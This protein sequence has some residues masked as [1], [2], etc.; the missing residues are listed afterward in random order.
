MNF[1]KLVKSIKVKRTAGP[2]V[3]MLLAFLS[4]LTL[5]QSIFTNPITNSNPSASNPFTFGQTVNTN[6]TVSG[7]GRGAGIS[8]NAGQDR[9][10]AN[11]WNTPSLDATA[12]FE[13]IITPNS[14]YGINFSSFVYSGQ[15]SGTGPT[16]FAFRSSLDNYST[17]IGTPTAPGTSISLSSASYQGIT[18]AITF[19][20]YGWGASGG[21]G[22]YSINDFTFNGTLTALPLYWDVTAGAGNGVGG[23]GIWGNTFSVSST[24]STSLTSSTASS[25]VN[26]EGTPGTVFLS[27][28]RT[29]NSIEVNVPGYTFSTSTTGDI[30]LTSPFDMNSNSITCSTG[31]SSNLI[32]SSVI[33][34]SVTASTTALTKTGDGTLTLG[35][36]N[37]FTG[38]VA[39]NG[40][41]IAASGEARF[42]PN[43]GSFTADQITLNGGGIATTASSN[44]DFSSNRGITLGLS[45]GTFSPASSQS[46]TL[47]NVV[48][49]SGRL[50]MSGSGTL[51][52]A[53]AHTY[54][55]NTTINSGTIRLNA[56]DRISNSSILQFSSG[57]FSTGSGSGFSETLGG[58]NLSGTGTI[59]LGTGDHSLTFANS[60]AITWGGSSLVITGWT[61]TAGSSGTGGKIFVG[62]GGLTSGQLAKVRFNGYPGSSEILPSGELVP[63]GASGLSD[64]ILNSFFTHPSNI[65]YQIHQASDIDFSGTS[66]HVAR[67]TIRD[68]GGASDVDVLGTT[69]TAITFSLS[70]HANIRRI[71]L[72]DGSTEVGEVNGAASISFGSLNI[73]A[74]DGD[75]KIFD[76]RV[77]FNST[78]TDNQ[79]FQFAITSATALASGSGFAAAD[80]G[81]AQSSIASN[82]NRIE[83]TATKLRYIQQP[84][85]VQAGSIISPN[86]S[87]EA[88]DANDNRDLDF[89]G[90]ITLSITSTTCGTLTGNAE[91]ASSGLA[92][93][94][95]LTPGVAENAITLA[96]SN[97]GSLTNATSSPT[98]NVTAAAASEETLVGWNF[99][100]E[101]TLRTSGNTNNTTNTL[102]T[103][104]TGSIS[105]FAGASGQAPGVTS[106]NGGLNTKWWEVS[107]NTTGYSTI[108]ISSKQYG[109]NNSP[110]NFN[111]Q[112]KI[113]VGGT[114]STITSVVVD[115]DW[116]SG[117]LS[118]V[119]VP[120]DAENKPSVFFRW[121]MSSNTAVDG[122]AVG[123]SGRSRIDDI[124]ITGVTLTPVANLFFRSKATGNFNAVCT[125]ESSTDNSTWVQAP[126]AP[127]FSSRTITIRDGHAV[128]I[129]SDV[130][131][132][133][134]VVAT[135]GTL[136][137]QDFD[138]NLN[139]GTGIDFQV[140]GTFIDNASNANGAAFSTS[141]TWSMGA[142]A[143]FIKTRNGPLIPF[144]TGYDGGISGIPATANWIWR[145]TGSN[146]SILSV[147]GMFYP[148]LTIESNSGVYA[149]TIEVFSGSSDFP[150]IKG[151][152]DIGG[153][154]SG[155]VTFL[156]NN[157]NTQ[158]LRISGDLIVRT[159]SSLS[160]NATGTGFEV[161]GN[162]A[163]DG[164]LIVS[165]AAPRR[166]ELT[167]TTQNQTI[168]GT[169]TLTISQFV[170]NNTQTVFLQKDLTVSLAFTSNAGTFDAGTNVLSG[171]GSAFTLANGASVKLGKL[172]ST[173]PEAFST[174]TLGTTSTV[175]LNGA[176]DQTLRDL[177]YG[178]LIFSG[179]GVKTLPSTELLV[180]GNLTING[181]STN[182]NNGTVTL[183]STGAQTIG[184][185]GTFTLY[186]LGTAS[187]GSKVA[188]ANINLQN[189]FTLSG[190]ATFDADGAAGN[191]LFSLVSTASGT[192]RIA[193][194][195]VPNNF[196][197]AIAMQRYNG[198]YRRARYFTPAVQGLT[199]QDLRD[200]ILI[201]GPSG[202]DGPVRLIS[203]IRY[204]NELS[205][206]TSN[207]LAWTSLR[208]TSDGL[209]PG[210]GYYLFVPGRR[211][212]AAMNS[213]P[214]VLVSQGL[215]NKGTV[216]L[217]VSNSTPI[218]PTLGVAGWNLVGNPYPCEINWD[219][220]TGWTKT[221]MN[222]AI[223]FWDP[224]IGLNGAYFSYVGGSTIS[225]D[226]RPNP[227]VIPSSQGFFVR[228]SGDNPVLQV[229]EA[230]KVTQPSHKPNFRTTGAENQ[231][232]RIK[233]QSSVTE[234]HAV[235]YWS[236]GATTSF[237]G[238]KDAFKLIS[239]ELNLALISEDQKLLSIQ[240]L[241]PAVDTFRV[242]L[243]LSSVTLG[244][245]TLSFVDVSKEEVFLADL[246]T[247]DTIQV[248][249]G[250]S[251]TFEVS[252]EPSS[253]G[254]SRF[255]LFKKPSPKVMEPEDE[256]QVLG[257]KSGISYIVYIFPNPVTQE[258]IIVS[259]IPNVKSLSIVSMEGKVVGIDTNPTLLG[260]M[261]W[262]TDLLSGQPAGSYVLQIQTND[263][264]Y[265]RLVVKP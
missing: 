230:A 197:G 233:V 153:N 221:N 79:Q 160:N 86:V 17:D 264:T 57:T 149:P 131:L 3:F 223:Y 244:A 116:T 183:N 123:S 13:F 210:R 141:A 178:H 165:G 69:L 249:E 99:D 137:L 151:N 256:D 121:I 27:A 126:S 22:T 159:G 122:G 56:S 169:G 8:A 161:Q 70:N 184:G 25:L 87:V 49:G 45:G 50:A 199:V 115:E 53:G 237:D 255:N 10:N 52:M 235:V 238:Q 225:L 92:T 89:T 202:F 26:F 234:D 150:T 35:S 148:N 201:N 212:G 164:T 232:I 174:Y 172:S 16:T 38:K 5:A 39:I 11:S 193:A 143:T 20:F 227:N 125:W 97:T 226:G 88:A 251:Y 167:S 15:A 215:P 105:Y 182:P 144:R 74:S 9:Y 203:S 113:G 106:W 179:S 107:V 156:N 110:R 19:R 243:D 114:W 59:A 30:T 177:D 171:S 145:Y 176:G 94:T 147:D 71:A 142:S 93:F 254:S 24:G 103:T 180:N 188:E 129:N 34:G 263:L 140:N 77:S 152:L 170:N 220:L 64:I 96:T 190:T 75:V 101:S 84:S 1:S 246:F 181:G 258:R 194:L 48:T 40:G 229:S 23:T 218:D 187:S 28:N 6:I 216:T 21:T 240:G 206:A 208:F 257:N 82:D 239:S 108:K 73:N 196:S 214:V 213:E 120:S 217:P 245:Q 209:T 118:N 185:T 76:L 68:G 146:I 90:T 242:W 95:T 111:L 36:N 4:N 173:L 109:S 163:I 37:T 207:N 18:S 204:Y 133:E 112:Y 117:V 211:N 247:G 260:N 7:I 58:L 63:P 102:S 241:D 81:G 253:K 46:I 175:E 186:N 12:Y 262:E 192:A 135:G 80:A 91:A 168:S 128:T 166:L 104:G 47:T 33:T 85:N 265:Q 236:E 29:V 42:G 127:D 157:T 32:L 250:V 65:S 130:T 189:T 72:Y 224:T 31:T 41:F 259:G 78:V 155:T 162:V 228:A 44:I 205:T 100:G 2:L 43:P 219:A 61:G 231:L 124:L 222:A 119:A 195:P 55:G 138:F 83:V 139:N 154:G 132:D 60:S 200:S 136:E 67:F 14:G 158:P 248:N 51:I 252:A 261:K 198:P 98:F 62:V 54:T 134:L 66:I 191:K